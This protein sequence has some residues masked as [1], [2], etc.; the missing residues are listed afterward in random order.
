MRKNS[1]KKDETPIVNIPPFKLND[2]LLNFNISDPGINAS[3]LNLSAYFPPPVGISFKFNRTVTFRL[4]PQTLE[5]DPE[6]LDQTIQRLPIGIPELW[7][8]IISNLSLKGKLNL[9]ETCKALYV[10]IHQHFDQ[11]LFHEKINYKST[12][13]LTNLFSRTSL[14]RYGTAPGYSAENSRVLKLFSFN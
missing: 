11:P 10:F 12:K 2:Q 7:I 1:D 6:S 13:N 4:Y 5:V 3:S 8:V 14:N 9:M